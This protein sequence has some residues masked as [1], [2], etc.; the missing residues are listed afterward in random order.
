MKTYK[1]YII[2]LVGLFLQSCL[3]E[4]LKPI[5]TDNNQAI[6]LVTISSNTSRRAYSFLSFKDKATFDNTIDNLETSYNTYDDN[7]IASYPNLKGEA[8]TDKEIEIGWDPYKPFKE[9]T[10]EYGLKRSLLDNY[11]KVEENW[12]NNEILV[13]ANDP[14]IAF[15]D[16]E[17]EQ[18][19]VLND[20]GVVKIGKEIFIQAQNGLITIPDG[21]IDTLFSFLDT[22]DFSGLDPISI[23]PNDLLGL[24]N[25]NFDWMPNNSDPVYSCAKA[26]TDR[27][28]WSYSSTRKLKGVVKS[29][30]DFFGGTK[31]KSKTKYYRRYWF[32]GYHWANT[33]AA[34]LTAALDGYADNETSNCGD[35]A[36]N[37]DE[38]IHYKTRTN[39]SKVKYVSGGNY[40]AGQHY[41]TQTHMLKGVHKRES[42]FRREHYLW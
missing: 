35:N 19:S 26:K 38:N 30:Y 9:F 25:L 24:G 2:I 17:P 4:D 8:L 37:F 34:I 12:L 42:S 13:E 31:I 14:D 15:N 22:L 18:L 20:D 23:D 7:F 3:E 36:V 16:L 6:K 41:E 21:N 40:W 27:E 33:R 29:T 5:D 32:F 39:K 10:K 1:F 11:I 28:W